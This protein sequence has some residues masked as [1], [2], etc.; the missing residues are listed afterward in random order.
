MQYTALAHASLTSDKTQDIG[1]DLR[2]I[3]TT[4][5]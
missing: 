4:K 3:Y 1:R 5:Q 2:I